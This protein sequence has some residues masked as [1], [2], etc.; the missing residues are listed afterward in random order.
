[1]AVIF[2]LNIKTNL[3]WGKHDISW[4]VKK[5]GE[6]KIIFVSALPKEAKNHEGQKQS[7]KIQLQYTFPL[8]DKLNLC[9]TY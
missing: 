7:Y 9:D 3:C 2:F 4:P 8:G 5:W 6:G 1:M